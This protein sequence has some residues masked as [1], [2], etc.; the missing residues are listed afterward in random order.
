MS[1]QDVPPTGATTT[2]PVPQVVIPTGQGRRPWGAWRIVLVILGAFVVLIAAAILAGGVV[3][4][5]TYQQRDSDGFYTAGPERFSTDTYAL[6]VPGF[7]IDAAGPDAIYADDILGDVRI[8]AESGNT[9]TP[10]FVGIGPADEVARYLQDVS[11]AQLADI[12]VDPFRATYLERPGDAPTADP[13]NQSWW[14]ASDSGTGP[15]TVTWEAA[16]GSWTVVIMNAD[17]TAGVDADISA[18][19]TLPVILPASLGAVAVGVV[20]LVI[21]IAVIVLTAATRPRAITPPAG[22]PGG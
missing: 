21:G 18:G 14:V 3:G 6:S 20:L 7:D 1:R 5:W 4:L 11:H 9:G 13:A 17:G 2:P 12:D 10:L 8:R 22:A 19:A 15:R 16:S